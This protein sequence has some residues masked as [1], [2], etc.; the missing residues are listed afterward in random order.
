MVKR[1][2][3]LGMVFFMWISSVAAAAEIDQVYNFY[4]AISDLWVKAV[5]KLP[6][7]PVTLVWKEVGSDTTPSGDRVVSGYFYADPDDF[8]YGSVY[9]P[10]VFVKIY[11]A[12]NGWANIAFN[13]VTVDDVEVYSTNWN[14]GDYSQTGKQ[15]TITLSQRLEEHQWT[16]DG[17]D[18][19]GAWNGS[20]V[21][22]EDNTTGTLILNVTQVGSD[23][24]GRAS[25]Y[26]T[27]CAT[28]DFNVSGTDQGSGSYSFWVD[29]SACGGEGAVLQYSC[30]LDGD[31]LTGTFEYTIN[32]TVSDRGT[33][34][35]EKS[36]GTTGATLTG[37][38]RAY[39]D[40]T[41][42][43]RVYLAEAP[44]YSD[45]SDNQGNIYISGIP[46]GSYT[47]VIEPPSSLTNC[48][49]HSFPVTFT[50]NTDSHDFNFNCSCW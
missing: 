23:V 32:G 49:N 46:A 14:P 22:T 3:V 25:I 48:S 50:T 44:N 9:N 29:G 18:I 21:D 16:I 5:L 26:N 40:I 20:W 36:N 38:A 35:L 8:A 10:E 47:I 24:T 28:T 11:I 2:A 33:I 27:K 1:S 7:S 37:V 30:K 15:G 13:H 4:N 43:I 42:G 34:S 45:V 41:E 12:S 19:T 17:E 31:N 39:G 6:G